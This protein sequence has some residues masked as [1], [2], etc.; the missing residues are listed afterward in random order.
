MHFSKAKNQDARIPPNLKEQQLHDAIMK[1][2]NSV[3]ENTGEFIGI[4]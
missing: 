4:F 1:A 2:I 3:V